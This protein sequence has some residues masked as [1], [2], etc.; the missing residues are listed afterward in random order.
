MSSAVLGSNKRY[1]ENGAINHSGY[2]APDVCALSV[3][4]SVMNGILPL[5]SYALKMITMI[6]QPTAQKSSK[7]SEILESTTLKVYKGLDGKYSTFK[8]LNTLR[9]CLKVMKASVA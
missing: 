7:L 6:L 1:A 3:R 5:T 9:N 2:R 4:Y 8:P